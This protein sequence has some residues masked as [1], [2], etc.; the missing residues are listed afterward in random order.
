M[1][2]RC[3]RPWAV[4]GTLG[5]VSVLSACQKPAAPVDEIRPVRTVVV[6]PQAV[7]GQ[8]ELTGVVRAR[9]ESPLSFR[10]AGKLVERKV[11]AGSRVVAGQALARLDPADASLSAAAASAALSAART[12]LAQARIDNQ[13][14]NDLLAKNFVS[15]AEVDRTLTALNAAQDTLKQAEAQARLAGNQ[16]AYATLSAD[17]AGVVTQVAAEPGQVVAAG[18][19]VLTLA[20][21]GA[22]EIEVAVPE[23]LRDA[24]KVG[25]ALQVKL[26]AVSGKTYH[27]SVRE[28]SPSADASSRTFAARV[29]LN[30]AD[31][32]VQLGMSA[33]VLVPTGDQTHTQ[34]FKLPLT[35]LLDVNGQKKLW[36]YDAA[37]HKVRSIP[38][39]V[40]GVTENGIVVEGVTPGTV[41]VTAGVHMLRE[42][43]T[44]KLI[45]NA[46]AGQT[47]SQPGA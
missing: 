42:G 25:Q 41:V 6:R 31:D 38:V 27:G 18:Q 13:R 2:D 8:A 33:T 14:A 40:K 45:S 26:W 28:L 19:P 16:A 23:N 24:L 34:D 15:R 7:A 36:R 12:Q 11:D 5:F 43:Q 37:S 22:R 10:L 35:A 20:R 46:A 39:K 3:I 21:D 1:N 44:V 9:V 29:T 4:L 17:A 47:A 32:G 30:D